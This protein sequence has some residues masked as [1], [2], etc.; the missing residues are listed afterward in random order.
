M[1]KNVCT[2]P[3]K[4][5]ALVNKRV[6]YETA[7]TSQRVGDGDKLLRTIEI[8]LLKEGEISC[9]VRLNTY[10]HK[11]HL[12]FH[13]YLNFSRILDFDFVYE[14]LSPQYSTVVGQ[15]FAVLR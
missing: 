9:K 13:P 15:A 4:T 11:L 3:R 12:T 1:R 8:E 5:R 6:Y 14:T 7:M 10:S 2:T